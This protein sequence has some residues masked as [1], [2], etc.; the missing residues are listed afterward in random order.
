MP[1]VMYWIIVFLLVQFSSRIEYPTSCPTLTFISSVTQAATDKAMT[2]WGCVHLILP[3]YEYP[4][5]WRY[6]GIVL[7]LNSPSCRLKSAPDDPAMLPKNLCGMDRLATFPPLKNLFM[8]W[9]WTSLQFISSFFHIALHLSILV[10]FLVFFWGMSP[11]I[12][13]TIIIS[14]YS[15]HAHEI[16]L[17]LLK[18]KII[19]FSF[20][21]Y[22]NSLFAFLFLLVPL[23]IQLSP[24]AIW[25]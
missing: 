6:C 9:C 21:I 15:I 13:V 3:N 2:Q 5:S 24:A 4:T 17:L 22:F 12:L 25:L 19:F 18:D 14:S 23:L 10:C 1:S 16:N 11:L 20:I 8:L 7:Y